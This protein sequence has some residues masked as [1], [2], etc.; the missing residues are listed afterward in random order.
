VRETFS[1]EKNRETKRQRE[2]DLVKRETERQ[3]ER[4]K[5]RERDF[6]KREI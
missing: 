3:R 1:E 5:E 4:D 6:V 2:R